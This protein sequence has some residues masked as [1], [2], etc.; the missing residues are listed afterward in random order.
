MIEL[1]GAAE[2]AEVGEGGVMGAMGPGG[3]AIDGLEGVA[4]LL[5]GEVGD[6]LDAGVAVMLVDD[7]FGVGAAAVE[8]SGF[9]ATGP[10][11][12]PGGFGHVMDEFLFDAVGRI[13]AIEIG[14]EKIVVGFG[15]FVVKDDV[16]VAG[17]A[18]LDGIARDALLA[19]GGGRA[20]GLGPVAARDLSALFGRQ[21][22]LASRHGISVSGGMGWGGGGSGVK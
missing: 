10:A 12:A 11:D 3:V 15:E 21:R 4:C 14:V 7:G 1:G 20:T 2:E 5:P 6:L 8:G 18:V 13:E 17:E 9:D 19:G 16:F 22:V